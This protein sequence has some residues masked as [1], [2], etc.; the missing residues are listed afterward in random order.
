M[1]T[2]TKAEQR[3]KTALAEFIN[4]GHPV[5][6]AIEPLREDAINR[7]EEEAKKIVKRVREELKENG[8]D[9]NKVAPYPE[10]NVPRYLYWVQ[11]SKYRLFSSLCEWRNGSYRP[12]EPCLADVDS[13]FVAK[14]VKASKE[15]A[16]VQYDAFV[17]KLCQKVGSCESATITGNHVWSH[18]FLVVEKTT[19]KEV[20]KTQQ[21]VNVSKLGKLFNQWPSRKVKV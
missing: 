14:F 20:W 13:N 15:S 8:N 12:G 2:L 16:A 5:A 3:T 9:L 4:T 18:S 17:V 7:A 1:A 19:G 6:V 10:S 11:L 21:I